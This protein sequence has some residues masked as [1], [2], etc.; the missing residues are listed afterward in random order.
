MESQQEKTNAI[1]TIDSQ[2]EQ[3]NPQI[4]EKSNTKKAS[5]TVS[6]TT[7]VGPLPD[8]NT[9]KNYN[10]I[11]P[12]GADRIMSLTEKQANHRMELEKRVVGGQMLQSNLGQIFALII[13][14]FS[15]ACA[16]YVILEGHEWAGSIIGVGG[17][18]SLV[19]AF[20]KGRDSQEKSLSEKQP[21]KL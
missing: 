14:L 11:I 16:T 17:L 10:D 21:D 13:G 8:P 18:T 3:G 19:T 15:L 9:L 5:L 2:L 7:H 12:N 4:I 6:R 20:I 1:S